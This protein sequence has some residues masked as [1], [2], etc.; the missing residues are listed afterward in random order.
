M[1]LTTLLVALE[2]TLEP[3][4]VAAK[5]KLNVADVE[6]DVYEMLNL[7]A[8]RWRLVI[9]PSGGESDES[10]DLGGYVT[11]TL[12]LFLQ[13][14]KPMTAGSS[15]GLHRQEGISRDVPFMARLAWVIAQVRGITM[16]SAQ[17]DTECS[18][19]FRFVDWDWVR[20][21]GFPTV[22]RAA[23][24]RFRIHYILDAPGTASTMLL[25]AANGFRVE[26]GE[27]YLTVIDATGEIVKQVRL[28][29]ITAGLDGD[30]L[31]LTSPG[32][33][34]KQIRLTDPA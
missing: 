12:S 22:L 10:G 18:R 19:P 20:V 33:T 24:I 15:K 34:V 1:N 2:S 16:E 5:G 14:T 9:T 30:Y 7:A 11:E 27:D 8:D 17:I 21:D 31:T 6:G 25:T 3:A 29:D 28:L 4:V 26:M 13:V 32:G 23:R